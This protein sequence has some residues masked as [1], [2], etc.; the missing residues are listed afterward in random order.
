MKVQPLTK[1]QAI[2][3]LQ[4]EEARCLQANKMPEATALVEARETLERGRGEDLWEIYSQAR[5]DQARW[6]RVKAVV[7]PRE[8]TG[9]EQAKTFL[10][11]TGAGLAVGGIGNFLVTGDPRHALVSTAVAGGMVLA[12]GLFLALSEDFKTDFSRILGA[13]NAT[14]AGVGLA[15]NH[16]VSGIAAGGA[17]LGVA[18]AIATF[19]HFQA[20]KHGQ[21]QAVITDHRP[22]FE[23]APSAS[24]QLGSAITKKD[25]LETVARRSQRAV[26]EGDYASAMDTREDLQRLS[27]LK[28]DTFHEMFLASRGIERERKLLTRYAEAI[29]EDARSRDDIKAMVAGEPSVAQLLIG[30]DAVEV[31]DQHLPVVSS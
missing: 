24:A 21:I 18:V 1:Q 11:L 23:A 6:K 13:F 27:D 22:L 2:G 19:G 30:D 26:E 10:G 7:L 8:Q 25:I 15:T 4:A 12:D 16:W 5:Q 17:T 20:G 9:R 14:T 3:R 28:G 31:G 29:L